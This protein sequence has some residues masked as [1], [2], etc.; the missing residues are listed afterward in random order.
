MSEPSSGHRVGLYAALMSIGTLISRI[1]GLLRESA[2]AA[3][4]PRW[5]TDAW[6]VAFRIPNIFRRLF[7]E[8]SLSVSFIPVFIQT[9][10]DTSD[11]MRVKNFTYSF[12]TLFT[13]FLLVL[14]A[15]GIIFM[16]PLL[17]LL[18]DLEYLKNQQVFDLTLKMSRI[19]IIYVW[20][21]CTYAFFM[22]ILNALGSYG[23]AAAAP[24]LFNFIMIISTVLPQ[25]WHLWPGQ[26]LAWG[27][28]L[29]G[30]LQAGV[31]IPLL[32]KKGFLPRWQIEFKNKDVHRVM[33]SMLP[34]L[35]GMGLLQLMTL[36]N[37]KYA[38]QIGSG[39]I[40]YIN[41]ADRLLELPLSLISVSLGAALL[42]SLSRYAS[43]KD[44][45][46]MSKTSSYHLLLNLFLSLPAALGAFVL[47]EPIVQILFQRG[48]FLEHET[49]LTA[50]VL[51][52]YSA[53]IITTSLVRVFV[54][55]YYAIKNTWFPALVSGVCLVIHLILAP[56]LIQNYGLNG[57][58]ISTVVASTLN[59]FLL[60]IGYRWFVGGYPWG[61][62]FK[63]ILYFLLAGA[64]M[65]ISLNLF[66]YLKPYLGDSFLLL[67][68][69][70]IV[71]ISVSLMV[72]F[73]LSYL[74]KIK[75]F[76]DM[77]K[78]IKARVSRA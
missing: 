63:H 61:Q 48:Q 44:F 64:G 29:G 71:T 36:V 2:F 27:V 40:S 26:W 77:F 16:E 41:L 9:Q 55:N 28:V 78:I 34:G 23:R 17:R 18:L 14:T 62:V 25:S 46:Q 49:L 6:Y 39:A 8:G 42:P 30:V 70:L 51:K 12:F 21:V 66:F 75:E 35:L 65:A 5:V 60:A 53:L 31:L 47:A 54:P 68:L 37:L 59:F 76:M 56:F 4:F 50:G 15:L 43:Q 45:N 73:I 10:M 57:L 11:P 19:M 22:A 52:I 69:N 32:I 3:L 74:L 72:Y 58:N 38:S 24:A 13:I 7:G 67:A 20:L 33:I 1:L